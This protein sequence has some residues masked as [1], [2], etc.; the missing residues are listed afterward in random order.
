LALIVDGR[1]LYV[2]NCSQEDLSALLADSSSLLSQ[3]AARQ[4]KYVGIAQ[5]LLAQLKGIGAKGFVPSLRAGDTGIG[6]TLESH[7]G[8]KANSRKAPDFHGI[9]IKSARMGRTGRVAG[10]QITLFSKKPDWGRSPY[11]ARR[12]LDVF[13]Y[14]DATS[15]R[16]Q[17]YCSIDASQANSLGFKLDPR[18]DDDHLV[19][20]NISQIQG[21]EDVFL[22]MMS[23]IKQTFAEKHRETF[24][25]G[26]QVKGVGG[27][28]SFHY[29]E[30]RHTRKPPLSTFER[31]L[32]EGGICV[33]LTM[34][35]RGV[36]AVRDHGYL[37]RVYGQDFADLFPE[38]G[39]Y[40]LV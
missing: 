34:S 36:N 22:W 1:Q 4:D 33:D 29:V 32:A 16:L 7:L 2:V 11:S 15:N 12:T 26:A 20:T 23:E 39:V 21:G 37:F 5:E 8:I 3:I 40:S 38:V 6:Y 10:K 9:E 14:R 30:A 27:S 28:E 13:G 19:T 24:C 17:L 18:A 25:V 35:E 31:L